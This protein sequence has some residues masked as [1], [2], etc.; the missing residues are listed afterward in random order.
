[1]PDKD[2]GTRSLQEITDKEFFVL[3]RK[4][5]DGA[6]AY[7]GTPHKPFCRLTK[8][9]RKRTVSGRKRVRKLILLTGLQVL[10]SPVGTGQ[11]FPRNVDSFEFAPSGKAIDEVGLKTPFNF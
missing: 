6:E 3:A 10:E 7:K 8:P 9:G 2:Q 5:R 1:V 11:I 4:S